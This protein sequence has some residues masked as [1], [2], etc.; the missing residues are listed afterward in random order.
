VIRLLVE[1]LVASKLLIDPDDTTTF[2]DEITFIKED[3]A[4]SVLL[5]KASVMNPVDDKFVIVE[6]VASKIGAD[7]LVITTSPAD[8]VPVFKLFNEIEFP[9]I[10]PDVNVSVTKLVPDKLKIF[11]KL[12]VEF[13][14]MTLLVTV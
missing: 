11:T 10:G 4:E 12:L 13:C 6:F 9:E 14:T 8:K 7:K 2:P 3:C 1:V 5:D